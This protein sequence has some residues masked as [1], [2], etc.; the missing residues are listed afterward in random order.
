MPARETFVA[1]IFSDLK[2]LVNAADEQP[3]VI[4][5]QC[6]AQIKFAAERVV[7]RLERLR[8]RA[9][10]NR[11]HRGRLDFDIAASCERNSESRG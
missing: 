8:R 7:K 3:L 5:L 6:D 4:K 2:Q 11:L 1:E 9:A 10:G